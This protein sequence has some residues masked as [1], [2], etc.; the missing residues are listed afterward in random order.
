MI[1]Q[2]LVQYYEDLL[3]NDKITRPGWTSAK[4]SWALELDENGQLMAL[5]PLHQE[6]K[7]GKKP[8]LV[9]LQLKVPEQVKRSRN[10][11]SNF[12]CENSAYMLGIGKKEKKEHALQCF[13]AA[14]ELHLTI[15]QNVPGQ[16]AQAVRGFFTNWEAKTAE[17]NPVLELNI[18]ELYKG[19]NLVFLVQ[20]HYAQEDAEIQEAWQRQC[21]KNTDAPEI[22][23]LVTGQKAPLARLHPA[24]KGVT[25]A[26]P[27]GASIVSFNAD[28][29][30]SYGH[31]QGGNAPVGSYAAFAYAQALNYLLADRE[32]V[33][34]VG[35]TTIVCWAAGG[36]TAYQ[37]VAMD[38]LFA[39]DAPVSESD[40]RN[41]VDKLVHGQSVEWQNVTLDP[42]RHFYV[43]GLAPNAARL[44]VRFFWQD[45]FQTLLDNV[46]KHY[47]RLEIVRPAYDKF[48]RLGL[49]WLLQE[50]V[51]TN[52]R[53]PSAAP[54]L[55]GDVLRAILNN[56]RYPATLL[57]GVMMRIRAEQKV[58]RGRAAIIKA[59]YLRNEDPRCPKEV[60]TVENNKET[61]Y[62]PYVMG[63]L[64]AVL[65]AI[66]MAVNPDINT[67]IKD[68]YFNAA[69][70][71]PATVFPTILMLA[72]KH[73]QKMSK[74][75]KIYY[76]KQIAA[77][78]GGKLE[79]NF[80]ARLTLP[81]QGSFILGYYHQTQERYTKKV[82]E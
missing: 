50:T 6:E 10:I 34:R 11:I 16:A 61:N 60:L 25:G 71:T 42:Q 66:Q 63:Q 36:E 37:Q 68:R 35:D 3:A 33:Q 30:C 26:Q 76:D 54:Q 44:S 58:T 65:E 51:N 5:H 72:Q 15:L 31:E 39:M 2:A 41:A 82:E 20:G 73:M 13:A 24:I 48:P 18:K 4:V 29:F 21:D 38:A 69:A 74:A 64:F 23:C 46:Q 12:M 22:R 77:L 49:Y 56:T 70:S 32:H 14:K 40:V 43:L 53:N 81:E 45:T 27:S 7:R 80:P 55:A 67:T 79:G 78:A 28:A 75:Q 59:Y 52:S 8:A 62:Q 47:D 9:P 19:G 17:Q 1:L 57:D